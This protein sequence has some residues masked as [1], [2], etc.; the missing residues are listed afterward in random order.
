[1]GQRLRLLGR[2]VETPADR[3]GGGEVD[4]E[5]K[6]LHLC[7]AERAQERVDLVDAADELRPGQPG[8]S[9]ELIDPYPLAAI[10]EA[11]EQV[12]SGQPNGKVIVVLAG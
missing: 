6:K 4:D 2:Q 1:M 5:G 8:A 12:E 11:H 7:A 3:P 10:A 9:G